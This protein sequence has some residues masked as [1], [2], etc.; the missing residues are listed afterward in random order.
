MAKRPKIKEAKAAELGLDILLPVRARRR[1]KQNSAALGPRIAAIRVEAGMT[2][3]ELASAAC[4]GLSSIR[5]IEQGDLGVNL[6][7]IIKIV[8]FLDCDL[9]VVPKPAGGSPS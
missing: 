8:G 1:Q 6:K 4:V 3:R 7:T 9:A 5:K 2:Q